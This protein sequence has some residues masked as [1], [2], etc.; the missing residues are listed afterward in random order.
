M[1]KYLL[2]ASATLALVVAACGGSSPTSQASPTSSCANAGAA[3]HAYIVIQHLSGASVQKCVGF[4]GDTIDGKTLMDQSG[5]EYQA[6][7]FS[8]GNAVCQID[9]EPAQFSKCF[10]ANAPYWSLFI[11]TG[12]AWA[13]ATKSFDVLQLHDKEAFGWHYVQQSD[14]S[15]APPPLASVG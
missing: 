11:E 15:P 8:F 2:G 3:H 13:S 9:N 7:S 1:R 5:I 14:P 4:A 6:Q 12:G 10:P